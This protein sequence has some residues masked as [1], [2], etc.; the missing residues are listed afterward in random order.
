[1]FNWSKKLIYQ[2]SL[3][4]MVCTH[5][6]LLMMLVRKSVLHWCQRMFNLNQRQTY[7]LLFRLMVCTLAILLM[8][9]EKKLAQVWCQK[10]TYNFHNHQSQGKNLITKLK[11]KMNGITSSQLHTSP[12]LVLKWSDP[13]CHHGLLISNLMTKE[14]FIQITLK[15]TGPVHQQQQRKTPESF[16]HDYE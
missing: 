3:N 12:T 9:M 14:Q 6:T 15:E 11:L 10:K 5:V 16:T 4:P 2:L 7:P 13:Q 1:M 8:I